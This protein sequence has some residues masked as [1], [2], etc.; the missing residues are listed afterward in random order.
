MSAYVV[1]TDTIDYIVTAAHKY[2]AAFA[3]PLSPVALGLHRGPMR[4]AALEKTCR[5]IAGRTSAPI[6]WSL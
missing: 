5:T 6:A 1:S 4:T 2:E 3:A